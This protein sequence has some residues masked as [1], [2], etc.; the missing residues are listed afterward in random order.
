MARRSFFVLYDV[1][2]ELAEVYHAVKSGALEPKRG[3]T[4]IRALSELA[5]LIEQ[6]RSERRLS[7]LDQKIGVLRQMLEGTPLEQL[8]S[9]IK[10]PVIEHGAIAVREE[11]DLLDGDGA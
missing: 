2:C 9:W 1:K 6:E 10:L 4:M 8:P 5:Q 3:N 11:R 7:V